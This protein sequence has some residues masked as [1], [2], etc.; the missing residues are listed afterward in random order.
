VQHL[1]TEL[2]EIP[3][4]TKERLFL[5]VIDKVNKNNLTHLLILDEAHL[6]DNNALVDLRLL[7]SF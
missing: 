4:L 6:L 5:Q 2:G 7:V 1:V 3:R